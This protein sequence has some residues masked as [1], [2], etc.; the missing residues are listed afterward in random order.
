MSKE[1]PTQRLQELL[2]DTCYPYDDGGLVFMT[3][4]V[5]ESIAHLR[6]WIEE[7]RAENGQLKEFIEETDNAEAYRQWCE[8]NKE[9]PG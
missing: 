4:S 1:N 7:L 2:K 8:C 5:S 3:N 6:Q 9:S